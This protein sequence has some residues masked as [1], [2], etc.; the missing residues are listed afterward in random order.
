MDEQ[1]DS[2]NV[3]RI[4]D[5]DDL[6]SLCK[7]LNEQQAK[8]IVIGG[9][10]VIAQGFLRA[11]ADIDLLVAKDP[12]NIARIKEAL[13][14]LKDQA[15]K[16]ILPEDLKTYTVVRVA[17]EFVV[18]LMGEACGQTFEDLD[19]DIELIDIGGVKIPYLSAKGL[20]KTKLGVR[21][22]DIQDRQFLESLPQNKK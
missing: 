15:V 16:D 20:L 17:D 10:A 2:K 19:K 3:S 1:D 4:P 12:K 9:F 5:L 13:L 7:H 14:Y 11:T 18:D 6:V 8:Y 22:K 21:P